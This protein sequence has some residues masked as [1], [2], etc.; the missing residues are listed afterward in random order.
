MKGAASLLICLLPLSSVHAADG[1]GKTTL[2]LRMPELR[3]IPT[4]IGS[5]YWATRHP[6]DVWRVVAP[7]TPDSGSTLSED[8][9]VK[10]A[11]F[12]AATGGQSACP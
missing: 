11:T 6:A 4:G 9:R 5:V 12:T 3:E 7:I 2:D 1:P 8:I 10:C